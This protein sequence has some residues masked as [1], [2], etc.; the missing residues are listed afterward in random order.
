LSAFDVDEVD[1]EVSGCRQGG[2]AGQ[3][4]DAWTQ[5]LYGEMLARPGATL[6]EQAAL[7]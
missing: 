3:K 1:F 2:R 7:A 6:P 4:Q 5:P